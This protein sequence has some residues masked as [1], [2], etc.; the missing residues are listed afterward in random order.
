V[1]AIRYSPRSTGQIY[2]YPRILKIMISLN[3]AAA[4]LAAT[5]VA[6]NLER[7]EFISH[8]IEYAH[9]LLAAIVDVILL[10]SLIRKDH[11][12]EETLKDKIVAGFMIGV[13]I[14]TMIASVVQVIVYNSMGKDEDGVPIGE[15]PSHFV[16]FTFDLVSALILYWFCMDNVFRCDLEQ[17]RILLSEDRN[18]TKIAETKDAKKYAQYSKGSNSNGNGKSSGDSGVRQRSSTGT[19]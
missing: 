12:K 4:L 7:F 3:V 14:A 13:S 8:Q 17:N 2:A 1:I 19:A 10:M 11:D 18:I 15:T 6:L 16:E 5:L 9:S